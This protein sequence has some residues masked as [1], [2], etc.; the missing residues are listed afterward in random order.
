MK[1]GFIGLGSIGIFMAQRLAQVGFDVTGCDIAPEMLAAFDWPG[2]RRE[3]DPIATAR[4]AEVLGLCVRTDA[5]LEALTAD[6]ALFAAV[7]AG[8]IAVIHSTVA[9]ELAQRLEHAAATHGVGLIDAGVSPGG[10][11]VGEGK[12]SI[13]VGG[14]DDAVA[15]AR[16]YL[17]ALGR[18]AHLGPVGRGLEGK[19]LNNLASTAGY[20]LAVSILELGRQRGFDPEVLRGALLAGSAQSFALQVAPGLLRPSGPGATGSLDSLHDLLK[21]DVDHA[22]HLAANPD[23]PALRVLLDAAQAMFDA[24]KARAAEQD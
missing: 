11:H 14:S 23:D 3:R 5:Q 17:E 16:P 19:L 22:A 21:K 15:K 18:V 4:G 12:A 24:L 1:V 13:F 20:G 10:P 9:P 6:G 2:T 7:G 8:G